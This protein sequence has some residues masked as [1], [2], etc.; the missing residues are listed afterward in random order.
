MC[1]VMRCCLFC[2]RFVFM[3][4]FVVGC[5]RIIRIVSFC[6]LLMHCL[7]C[8]CLCFCVWMCVLCAIYHVW[9][10]LCCSL[11]A[12]IVCVPWMFMFRVLAFVCVLCVGLSM[13]GLCC[14]FCIFVFVGCFEFIRWF[15]F[16]LIF[17]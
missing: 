9:F 11:K 12:Y 6:F 13:F 3:G 15:V 7:H 14:V 16:L 10:V 8:C 5:I 2:V 4:W 17:C 1:F